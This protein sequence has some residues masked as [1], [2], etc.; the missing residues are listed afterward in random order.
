VGRNARSVAEVAK[1]LGCDWH[2]VND[3]VLAYGEALVD[4][5][6][7]FGTAG[8]GCPSEVSFATD[9]GQ[10]VATVCP[11]TDPKWATL[12]IADQGGAGGTQ[13]LTV[14]A[15]GTHPPWEQILNLAATP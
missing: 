5:P 10:S 2:T 9:T 14:S 12:T 13:A 15:D 3:A 6:G 1:E 8:Y 11:K 7:R 4:E